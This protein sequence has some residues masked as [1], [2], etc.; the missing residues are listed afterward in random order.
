MLM[1]CYTGLMSAVPSNNGQ[2]VVSKGNPSRPSRARRLIR[3]IAVLI[4]VAIVAGVIV[5]VLN[6]QSEENKLRQASLETSLNGAE[7]RSDDNQII[8][9]ASELIEGENDGKFKIADSPLSDIYLARATSYLNQKKYQLAADDFAKAGK[10][11]SENQKASLQGEIMARHALGQ[12]K[13]LIPL[14][15]KLIEVT[16]KSDIPN[17]SSSITQ[18]QGSIDK[19]QKGQDIEL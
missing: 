13:E 5:G 2:A 9:I 18:Y 10:L 14:F 15:E 19:L 6:H 17:A 12:K 3:G 16:K 7:N 1:A 4:L 11:S 8:S